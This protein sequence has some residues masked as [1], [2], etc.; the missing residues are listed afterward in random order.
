MMK[1]GINGIIKKIRNRVGTVNPVYLSID[2]D[3]LDPACKYIVN[4]SSIFEKE[5]SLSNTRISRPRN[6]HSRNRRLVDP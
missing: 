4:R 1:T 6:W 2:I 3:T 5:L